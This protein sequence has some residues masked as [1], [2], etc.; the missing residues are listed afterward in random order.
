MRKIIRFGAIFL[1]VA[2]LMA[3]TSCASTKP[4]EHDQGKHE[5]WYKNPNN[6]HHPEST[7]EKP[8]KN[9]KK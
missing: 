7:K 6:P 3:T 5:G 4:L 1:S 2:M 9:P 8:K